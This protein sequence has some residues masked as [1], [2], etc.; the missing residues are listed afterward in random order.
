MPSR[1]D[2]EEAFRR[3]GEYL[4]VAGIHLRIVVVG[5]AALNLLGLVSRATADADVIAFERNGE[6]V[7]PETIPPAFS[8]GIAAVADSLGLAPDW[9]NTGP[10]LQMR[11]G[12]PPGF[13]ERL[14][15]RTFDT[16]M[17]GLASR[18]DLICL[19][20][21]A[22][23]DHWPDRGVHFRDLAA[24]G[25]SGEELTW[26]AGWVTSQDASATFPRIVEAVVQA[27]GENA[28]Q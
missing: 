9:L 1:S 26:A 22:A 18:R 3:L 27:V 14:T 5:G 28:A 4:Q 8:D 25:P 10:A 12:L 24:L 19:K 21:F 15:W 6:L 13:R 20:L 2:F 17:V 7:P 16:L 11:F 23:A